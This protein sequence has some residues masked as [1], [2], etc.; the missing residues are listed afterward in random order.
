MM[1]HMKKAISFV[2]AVCLLAGNS[3]VNPKAE[4]AVSMSEWT[5]VVQETPAS[6]A[7]ELTTK[8]SE[9]LQP[10]LPEARKDM[11]EPK[12]RVASA[13]K[14]E[15]V[16][17]SDRYAFYRPN[18][19]GGVLGTGEV[20]KLDNNEMT[21]TV[22]K[23]DSKGNPI[24][25]DSNIS[26]RL[27]SGNEEV[28]SIKEQGA[29]SSG[30]SG[31]IVR[32]GPGYAQI[33][34][35]ITDPNTNQTYIITCYV[36]VDLNVVKDNSD[37]W[38]KYPQDSEESVLVL[39][40]PSTY[41]VELKYLNKDQI[42]GLE[43]TWDW[44]NDGVISISKDGKITALGAGTSIVSIK[45]DTND[46]K[47]N[48]D[49]T[50]FE[51]VVRPEGSDKYDAELNGYK[52]EVPIRT[53]EKNFYIYS[54][55]NPASNME[56]KVYQVLYN[57]SVEEL[58]E[59]TSK[60]ADILRY[61]INDTSGRVDFTDVSAGTYRVVGYASEKKYKEEPWNK[62]VYDIVVDV[63]IKDSTIYLGVNDIYNVVANSNIRQ[64]T[65]ADYFVLRAIDDDLVNVTTDGLVTAKQKGNKAAQVSVTYKGKTLAKGIKSI[66]APSDDKDSSYN[67][68]ALYSFEISDGIT[69]NS[70]S[71]N[72]Y[73][74]TTYQLLANVTNYSVPLVWASSDP[75]RVTVDQNGLITALKPTETDPA[76]PVEITVSQ[77]SGNILRTAVCK[78][79]VQQAVTAVTLDPSS[80]VMEIDDYATIKATIKPD[81]LTGTKLTWLSSNPK[82]FTVSESGD[83]SAVIK[84][85]SGGSAVLTAINAE[86]IVVGYCEVKVN[87]PATGIKLSETNVTVKYERGKTYQL[88][89]TLLPENATNGNVIWESQNTKIA[90][91]DKNGLVSFKSAG[92]VTISVQSEDNPALITYCTFTVQSTVTGVK[93]D[94]EELEMYVGD[95]KR[96]TYLI[97]P[98]NATNVAVNW[99]VVDTS[100]VTVDKTGMVTAKGPGKTTI[101]IM[102][103][104]GS[105]YDI[106]TVTVDQY[107]TGVKMNYT[108]IV[109]NRGDYFDMEV[110][111]TPATSTINSLTWE[112]LK[113]SVVTV[114]TTGRITARGVGEAIVMVKTQNGVFSYCNITVLEPIVSFA[115]DE[116]EINIDVGE[117][118][119]LTPV[120]TPEAPSNTEVIW[121]SNKPSVAE[122]SLTG[123]ITGK[124]GGVAVISCETMDGGY[125]A[126]C[127]VTVEEPVIE[128]TL[129]PEAYM[130]GLGKE[131]QLVATVTNDGTASDNDIIWT[132]DNEA[133]CTVSEKGKVTGI[134]LGTA[135]I[136]AEAAD[137][138]GA[139][140]LCEI[141][142]VRE[143]TT[144]KLNNSYVEVIQ[145]QTVSIH[146]DVQPSN[147]T[148]HD[149]IFETENS[150]IAVID[151]DGLITGITPGEVW[152]T[153]KAK[154]NGGRIAK[155]RVRVIAPVSAT[156]VTVSDKE[157]VLVPG[158]SKDVVATIRPTNSTDDMMW[159]S[160]NEY[161][162]TVSGNGTITA[163][164]TGT[165]TITV[166]TTSG[167]TAAINVVVLGLSRTTLQLPVYTKYSSLLVD[168][169]TT[170]VRWDVENN[171]ICE[172]RNGV[173]TARKVGTTYV[174]ATVNGRTLRCKVTVTPN[175]K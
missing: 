99:T 72:M 55:G 133:V 90:T 23:V 107:A 54:N 121:E 78:V 163:R 146:A 9:A 57:G 157:I 35:Y 37:V 100:V 106:C 119:T 64:G 74:G 101:M 27:E 16:T 12:V 122:V 94:Q 45:T 44:T 141:T 32:E 161:I 160:S 151:E 143:V 73:T 142:V 48:P 109:M 63:D 83:L 77:E 79:Y 96:L 175:K 87:Q 139:Y 46:E 22:T 145:G 59:V 51:V 10:L 30:Y 38:K 89:A 155:C 144:I 104:E 14:N 92:N 85:V 2:M 39:D 49:I 112:S 82:V 33:I 81:N 148:Y 169:A 42:S 156:G 134:G 126:F 162:A 47:G 4:S 76:V 84:A 86:N 158:E 152:I 52:S 174:T 6:E 91:V 130:L 25:L 19:T 50:T 5:E 53:S 131:Y 124:S 58:V 18:D 153:A 7:Q 135:T 149:V 105:Y 172:V 129:E 67:K 66:Y 140:A 102:T 20:V 108:D 75:S 117:T 40:Q 56:W 69:L 159:F 128:I 13:A 3:Y 88:Y 61:V 15:E 26:V 21:L 167:K 1:K 166:M 120:F 125:K 41:E 95:S 98:A 71:L 70:T 138:Y 137:G 43:V 123:E 168:G 136:K 115:L 103:E 165:A 11:L 173:I 68:S 164:T 132:S 17:G 170:T 114:S 154:D 111:V 24:G 171:S 28:I 93:L 60:N 97:S 29:G 80:I 31:K 62:V 8:L 65:F 34:A 116:D 118:F 127:I 36:N 110:T 147:A 150:E 113:P